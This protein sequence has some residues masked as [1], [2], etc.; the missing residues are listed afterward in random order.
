MKSFLFALFVFVFGGLSAQNQNHYILGTNGLNS[1]VKSFGFNYRPI[2]TVYQ[3]D[4]I[5]NQHGKRISLPPPD[6]RNNT[7]LYFWQNYFSYFSC[8]Q[9]FGGTLG[10]QVNVPF[11]TNQPASAVI[12]RSLHFKDGKLRLSDLYVEPIN[13]IWRW[14]QI[15]LMLAYGFYAPTGEYKP[16]SNN[17][18]GLGNWGNVF[19]AASTFFWDYE[20]TFS[21]SVYANY[22]FHSRNRDTNFTPGNNFCLDWGV[23]KTFTDCYC[24]SIITFGVV[25]YFERQTC[26]DSGSHI[27]RRV[28]KIRDKVFAVG[29]E[30]NVRFVSLKGTLAARYEVEFN[31]V[32]R[33]QGKTLTIDANFNF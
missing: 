3:I 28:E 33:T 25:G 7:N 30:L 13:V 16:F 8:Y 32:S 14:D 4:Q 2:L 19:T 1:A 27:R 17:N 22:E 29:P 23:G 20:K 21:L 5:N 15:F 24:N 31:A 6:S 12:D 10:W 18:S 26:E 9:I 11:A